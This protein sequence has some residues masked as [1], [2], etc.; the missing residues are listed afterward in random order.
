[1]IVRLEGKQKGLWYSFTEN[2][3]GGPVRA[4]QVENDVKLAE[5]TKMAVDLAKGLKLV[6]SDQFSE[7]SVSLALL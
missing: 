7:L 2:K 4:I 6:K 1:M 3:G 5:A